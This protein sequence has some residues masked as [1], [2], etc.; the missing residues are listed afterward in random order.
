MENELLK[1]AIGKGDPT[2]RIVRLERNYFEEKLL[3]NDLRKK[4][5]SSSKQNRDFSLKIRKLE[6]ESGT[7]QALSPMVSSNGRSQ[8]MS[9]LNENEMLTLD[10]VGV[11]SNDRKTNPP[12]TLTPK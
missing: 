6:M 9:N 2:E 4:L 3:N 12:E 7:R 1:D 8:S 5:Q 11:V 10:N